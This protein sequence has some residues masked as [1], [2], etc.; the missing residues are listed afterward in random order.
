[1]LH[2]APD[3]E[4]PAQQR[5]RA[6]HVAGP[7][8]RPDAGG[9][10]GAIGI[11]HRADHGGAETIGSAHRRQ[12]SHGAGAALAKGEIIAGHHAGHAQPLHQP[13][14]HEIRRRQCRQPGIKRHHH[15]PIHAKI[16]QPIAP[17]RHGGKRK[18]RRIRPEQPGRVR[19]ETGHQRRAAL[20]P[21]LR[22]RR[23]NHGAM[24]AVKAIEIAQRHH[25]AA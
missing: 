22:Q 16:S 23:A 14:R 25:P 5:R 1:M 3:G 24:A 19:I 17:L 2:L 9:R 18:G 13:L 12:I 4:G 11:L 8:Q 10:Y 21:R 6:G 7:Q 15:Q 20:C